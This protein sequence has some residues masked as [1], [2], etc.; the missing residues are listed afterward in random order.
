VEHTSSQLF[1]AR[2]LAVYPNSNIVED[3]LLL[4]ICKPCLVRSEA[5]VGQRNFGGFGIVVDG[6]DCGVDYVWMSQQYVF[7]FGRGDLETT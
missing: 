2:Q 5:H 1:I 3:F 6:T 4:A 7:E